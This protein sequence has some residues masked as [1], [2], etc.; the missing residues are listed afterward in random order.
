MSQV[1]DV[2]K[3]VHPGYANLGWKSLTFFGIGL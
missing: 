1:T 3:M 2:Q